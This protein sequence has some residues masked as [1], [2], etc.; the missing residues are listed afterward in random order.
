MLCFISEVGKNKC[1]TV[2]T[3]TAGAISGQ[4]SKFCVAM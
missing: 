2:K 3:R 1:A 4:H